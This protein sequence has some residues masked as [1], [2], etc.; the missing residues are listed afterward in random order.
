[1]SIAFIGGTGL[2]RLGGE[3]RPRTVATPYGE[4][5]VQVGRLADQG[6]IFLPR[7]GPAHDVPPHAINYRAN[8][9]ALKQLGVTMVVASSAVGTLSPRVRPGQLALLTDFIDQ[10]SGRERTFFSDRVVHLDYTE[11][12]CPSLRGA[13]LAAADRCGLELVEGA[14]YVCTNG[15]RFETPAEI[16]MYAAL[17]ADV[18]GMTNLPEAVLAREAELCY[19]AVAIGTNAAA[20]LSQERLTHGEVEEMM[21]ARL[22]DLCRLLAEFAA[23]P[24]TTD[25][26]CRHALDEY[27]RRGGPEPWP[28]R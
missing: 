15:P 11:P 18:V 8:L 27:R 10:T 14:T 2:Y 20:G 25:C 4:A 16:R 7:H 28:A 19:A 17:G 22:A 21:A 24:P 1:M 9:A 5:R 23:A 6:V 13:L 12:Y 3:T 26:S